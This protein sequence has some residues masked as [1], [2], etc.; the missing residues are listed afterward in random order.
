MILL[1]KADSTDVVMDTTC[2]LSSATDRCV[3][4]GNSGVLSLAA[5]ESAKGLPGWAWPMDRSGWI[6]AAR[7]FRYSGASKACC[8]TDTNAGS[9]TQASRSAKA[10]R[11]ASEK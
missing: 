4:E 9:A 3:V 2:P 8:G 5:C 6:K 10:K 1:P 7:D 11:P